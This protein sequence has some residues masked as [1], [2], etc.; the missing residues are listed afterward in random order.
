[1][2]NFRIFAEVLAHGY[3]NDG[4]KVELKER[5]SSAQEFIGL[6]TLEGIYGVIFAGH[7]GASGLLADPKTGVF[8]YPTQV[9]PPYRLAIGGFYACQSDKFNPDVDNGRWRDHI[10]IDH[11]GMYIGFSGLAWW[12][13]KPVT[14]N[15]LA[16]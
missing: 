14:L 5:A 10:A 4:F 9:T 16:P 11:G 12:W 6:W 8:V 15:P 1:M 2:N 13:T 3:H 7:G